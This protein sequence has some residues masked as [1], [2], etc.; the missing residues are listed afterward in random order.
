VPALDREGLFAQ[1]A[2]PAKLRGTMKIPK[3][4]KKA[5]QDA[6]QNPLANRALCDALCWAV[7]EI[8]IANDRVE[9]K[10][11]D[12]SYA[13][14]AHA[15]LMNEYRHTTVRLAH[16]NGR[17]ESLPGWPACFTDRKRTGL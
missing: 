13:D 8:M 2:S 5:Y 9:G 7:A 12:K 4:Y 6:I 10:E 3:E 16:L 11:Q 1:K 14:D 15:M 17:A